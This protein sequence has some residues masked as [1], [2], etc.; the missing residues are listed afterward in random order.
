MIA[1]V[2]GIAIG[3]PITLIMGR[4]L[5]KANGILTALIVIPITTY[6]FAL[7][8]VGI[9]RGLNASIDGF[10]P[11]FIAGLETFMALLV[12]L[13]YVELRTRKGLRIDDFIQTSITLLP[14]VS[15]AIALASQFW[16]GFLATG[17]L[18]ILIVVAG[19]LRNPGK[20]L[21]LKPCPP[22]FG[23]CLTDENSLMSVIVGGR[24]LVGG[25]ALRE[26]PR[27]G[28]LI[29]CMKRAEG[30]SPMRKVVGF[31]V[32]LAP[33]GAMMLPFGEI[34]VAVGLVAAYVSTLT[35][36]AMLTKGRSI[37]CPELAKE[38]RN[39]LKEKKRKIDVAV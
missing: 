8:E 2:M 26:F 16:P 20:G 4:L 30:I 25:R 3:I 31:L 33:L 24:I 37:P 7:Y 36:A 32:S 14:Y 22:E 10:S 23:D 1:L 15:L 11:E 28:E 13:A 39:F 35:A 18:L 21:S 6:A 17:M 34:T 5:G 29:E 12:A 19:S 38:Y 9:F 27:A